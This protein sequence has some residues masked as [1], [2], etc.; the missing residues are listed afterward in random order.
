MLPCYHYR[1]AAMLLSCYQHAITPS[2]AH[3]S[4]GWVS[5]GE[6]GKERSVWLCASGVLITMWLCHAHFACLDK[7][8][9]K[10]GQCGSNE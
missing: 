7:V 9:E 4:T 8:K 10:E 2:A 5:E 3:C 6:S 1:H